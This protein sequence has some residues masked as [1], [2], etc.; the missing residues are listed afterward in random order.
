MSKHNLST[1]RPGTMVGFI[2]ATKTRKT[3][4]AREVVR[5][6]FHADKRLR[7]FVWDAGEVNGQFVSG[8]YNEKTGEFTHNP[9]SLDIR[10]CFIYKSIDQARKLLTENPAQLYKYTHHVFQGELDFLEFVDLSIEIGGVVLIVDEIDRVLDKHTIPKAVERIANTGRHIEGS[11]GWG[12]SLLFAARRLQKLHNDLLSAIFST[13]VAFITKTGLA[14]DRKKIEEES[15]VEG[16][17]EMIKALD[18]KQGEFIRV[19]DGEVIKGPIQELLTIRTFNPAIFDQH[20]SKH[21]KNQVEGEL[22]TDATPNTT[23]EN[24]VD[25]MEF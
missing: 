20:V 7:S 18:K 17:G 16:I 11:K 15:G 3:T 24:S 14:K 19:E 1:E 8:I 5:T 22:T 23:Q 21:I 10:D 25:Y 6:T 12:V 9:G 2:G 4:L 13:G